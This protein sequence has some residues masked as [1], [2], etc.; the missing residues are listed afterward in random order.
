MFFRKMYKNAINLILISIGISMVAVI[1]SLAIA[2]PRFIALDK[3]LGIYSDYVTEDTINY[4]WFKDGTLDVGEYMQAKHRYDQVMTSIEIQY[5]IFALVPSILLNFYVGLRADSMYKKHVF[6]NIANKDKGGT[7]GWSVLLALIIG[8]LGIRIVTA[9]AAVIV[10][11]L[12]QLI[13]L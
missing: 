2:V 3:E 7:S 8:P 1:L 10:L 4:D 9:I 13:I 11:I 12:V 5:S 6:K